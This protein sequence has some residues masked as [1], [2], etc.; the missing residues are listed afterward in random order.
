MIGED[1]LV[2]FK[3]CHH[4][5]ASTIVLRGANNHILDEAERSIHDAL[6]VLTQA[7]QNSRFIYGGGNS[8]INCANAIYELAKKES[9]KQS[10]AIEA[11][12]NALRELPLIVCENAGLDASELVTELRSKISNGFVDSGIDVNNKCIGN[13]KD[14]GI[15]ECLKVKYTAIKSA[16][17]AAEQILRVD[18]IIK[19]APRKREEWL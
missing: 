12:A 2:Q 6:C 13:M 8:E 16:A 18:D 10:L 11:F 15:M 14:L 4:K 5:G 9:G 17:E 3:G 19:C 1:R 7:I